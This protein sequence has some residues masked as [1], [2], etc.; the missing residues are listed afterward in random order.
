VIPGPEALG[1]PAVSLHRLG[2]SRERLRRA[3]VGLARTA[4]ALGWA[5]RNSP[6]GIAGRRVHCVV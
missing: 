2:R 1:R 4:V 5:V 6:K 3:A